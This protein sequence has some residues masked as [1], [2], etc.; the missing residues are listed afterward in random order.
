MKSVMKVFGT[1]ATVG[2]RMA[3]AHADEKAIAMGL[4]SREQMPT[5]TGVREPTPEDA[6]HA[7]ASTDR[8]AVRR[9]H[10]EGAVS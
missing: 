8:A 1:A 6:G 3:S 10:F 5:L 9:P 4:L 2:A 7:L